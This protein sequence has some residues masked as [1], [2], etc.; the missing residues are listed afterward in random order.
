MPIRKKTIE[1]IKSLKAI[2][3]FT[4]LFG[5]FIGKIIPN[6]S[7]LFTFAYQ[8]YRN[9]LQSKS[10]G[11]SGYQ[12]LQISESIKA[13][14]NDRKIEV[15]EPHRVRTKL[16]SHP[17]IG[18]PE[19]EKHPYANFYLEA[20]AHF[21]SSLAIKR[22]LGQREAHWTEAMKRPREERLKDFKRSLGYHEKIPPRCELRFKKRLSDRNGAPIEELSLTG[23][24]GA[25]FK[26]LKSLPGEKSNGVLIALH[27][28]NSSPDF[29]MGVSKS[30]DYSRAF[31]EF[32]NKK[33]FEVYA[34]QIDWGLND[35]AIQFNYSSVGVD[36][37]TIID[38]ILYIKSIDPK[39]S[40]II[41]GIS[42][43]AHLA[44]FVGAISDEISTIIS[45]GGI[46][47]GDYFDRLQAG[48]IKANPRRP[49][50]LSYLPPEFYFHY[51][52][53]G[54]IRLIAPKNLVLSVG[55][56]DW[57]E[58]KFSLIFDAIDYYYQIGSAR[59]LSLNIFKG[60]HE[61]D[62]EGEYIAYKNLGR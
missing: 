42:Y 35:H 61:S 13:E 47:R 25:T 31:G 30:N 17:P 50:S 16:F 26:V 59:Y 20:E 21:N 5:V 45:I 9:L 49:A 3:A 58:E 11:L 54:L 28:R 40:I 48:V 62:P 1:Q 32:W 52:G 55:T 36:I 41:A 4:F 6:H 23:R 10:V 22:G 60:Y 24:F 15:R 44:E 51:S 39:D 38:L 37:A 27:G 7:E 46:A 43:G 53:L 18:S 29:V 2:I 19:L 33:G 14:L 56:H 8:A 34:P 12:N 57:G